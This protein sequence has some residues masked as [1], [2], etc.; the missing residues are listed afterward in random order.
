[1]SGDLH[2]TPRESVE[3]PTNTLILENGWKCKAVKWLSCICIEIK[4]E[5]QV[6]AILVDFLNRSTADTI[7]TFIDKASILVHCWTLDLGRCVRGFH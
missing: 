2:L 7:A 3:R 6:S 4:H 5:I 1:M